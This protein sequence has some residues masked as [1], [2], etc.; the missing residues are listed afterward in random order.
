MDKL[1]H[2]TTLD[3]GE[4]SLL[5]QATVTSHRAQAHYDQQAPGRQT[6]DALS[7]L[8]GEERH[9]ATANGTITAAHR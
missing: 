3:D 6:Q 1:R 7:A 5:A 4:L 2:K 9:Q 8:R